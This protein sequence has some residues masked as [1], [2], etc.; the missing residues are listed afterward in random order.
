MTCSIP[1]RPGIEEKIRNIVRGD[2]PWSLRYLNEFVSLKC[3]PDLLALGL[4]PNA[5]EISESLGAFEIV[6]KH[7]HSFKVEDQNVILLAVGDGCT[8]RT[9]ALFA[10]RT[11]WE[12]WSIDPLLRNNEQWKTIRR[13]HLSP[14]KIED[15][16][17][18]P[19]FISDKKIIVVAVH[20]HARL[21]EVIKKLN[22]LTASIISIQC[23]V[24]QVIPNMEPD[25]EYRDWSI[26][27]P[28]NLVKIWK[29][30]KF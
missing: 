16:C 20:S 21:E 14:C 4:F 24:P 11:K 25:L 19:S 1:L 3:A 15:W 5:K 26:L 8:P 9:A 2:V 18:W 30:K 27:S 28:E 29:E 23:C 12:C 22:G 6:R 10:F 17:D 13:L 7:L